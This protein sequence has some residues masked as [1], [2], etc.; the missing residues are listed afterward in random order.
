MVAALHD[1]AIDAFSRAFERRPSLLARAP[2]RVNLIG[3]HTDY[4]DGFVLPCAIGVETAV[5]ARPRSDDVIRVFAADYQSKDEFRVD[6]AYSPEPGKLWARY[7]RGVVR[8]LRDDGVILRGAELAICGD[9]PQGAGLSSSAS[10]E[11]AVGLVMATLA[12]VADIDRA[13]LARIAQ[14]AENDFVGCKCGVMDQ[15]IS[16]CGVADA[17]V[18]IDCRDFSLAP[19]PIPSDLAVLIIHSGVTRGLVDGEYN[20]RRAECERAA[21][22]LPVASLRDADLIQLEAGR[23]LMDETAFR[24]ARHVITENRR[25]LDA[26]QALQSGDLVAL[27]RLMAASHDS[28]RD[29]FAITTPEIDRLVEILSRAMGPEGGARMTGGGFGGCVVALVPAQNVQALC[30]TVTREYRPPS[31]KPLLILKERATAGASVSLI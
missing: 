1:R 10:L 17:A 14:R 5:A 26:A 18:L 15:L 4:N 22:A 13:R 6:D 27:G 29:D 12:G 23:D 8:A 28:M 3:E 20:A 31:L 7:V 25:T 11:I 2:G 16:A 9:I 19:A 24:R 30:E 21:R